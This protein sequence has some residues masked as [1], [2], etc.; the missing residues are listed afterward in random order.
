MND[1]PVAI[2]WACLRQPLARFAMAAVVVASTV[3][4]T[5]Y[6]GAEAAAV[7]G[8]QEHRLQVA[9]ERH[10]HLRLSKQTLATYRDRFH[11]YQARGLI[12][13]E[14]RLGWL[15]RL[16]VAAHELDLSS[17]RYALAAQ[18]AYR[19]TTLE[20]PGAVTASEMALRM[21]LRHEGDLID[22]LDRLRDEA[23]ELLWTRACDLRRPADGPTLE[24]E[25]TLLWLTVHTGGRDDE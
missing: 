17:L 4:A 5:A 11:A 21:T 9:R 22:L 14:N 12:D 25:C 10:F 19:P 1:G 2:D 15:E 6:L 7:N 24:A 18:G 20:V 3:G 23:H 16:Q 8:E 13:R